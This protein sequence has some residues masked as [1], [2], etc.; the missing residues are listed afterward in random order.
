M[1]PISIFVVLYD[2]FTKKNKISTFMNTINPDTYKHVL[3]LLIVGQSTIKMKAEQVNN[4]NNSA[5]KNPF[6]GLEPDVHHQA[7]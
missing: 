5:K 2:C 7:Y 4:F 1:K 3:S 6:Y